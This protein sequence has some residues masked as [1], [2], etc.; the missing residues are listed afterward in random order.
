MADAAR[1][2]QFDITVVDR[3]TRDVQKI[4][5]DATRQAEKATAKIPIIAEDKATAEIRRVQAQTE[6]LF[7]VASRP[8]S[9]TIRDLAT[10]G[11]MKIDAAITA[12]RAKAIIPVSLGTGAAV[13]GL[14]V[15]VLGAVG[16]GAGIAASVPAAADL[17]AALVRITKLTGLEGDAARGLQTDL[18]KMMIQTGLSLDQLSGAY[19]LAGSAGIGS[20]LMKAGDFEGARKEINDFVTVT[21]QASSAFGM[22]AEAT[23]SAL[24]GISNVFKPAEKSV[25]QF[26]NQ[27][28]SGIDA[29]ADS[30]VASEEKILTA[31]SHA[32]AAMAMFKT[33]DKMVKDTIALSAALISTNKSGDQ[34]GEII[35]D[36]YTYAK[37]DAEGKI[38]K[39]LGMSQKDYQA[40][41]TTD[42]QAV[43]DLVA[44][45]Y[46]KM[47]A[48]KQGT[49]AMYFGATGGQALQLSGSENFQKGYAKAQAVVND[50]Y[51]RGAKMA[52]SYEKSL[53]TFWAQLDRLKRT[54]TVLAQVVGGI[55]LPGLNLALRAINAVTGPVVLLV[56]KLTELG[57]KIPGAKFIA[58]ALSLA[59][60][61][62]AVGAVVS[63]VGPLVAGLGLASVAAGVL[64]MWVNLLGLSVGAVVGILASPIVLILGLAA[65]VGY[66]LYKTGY[67]QKAWDKFK[68]SQLGEDF[69]AL[70][71]FLKGGAGSLGGAISAKLEILSPKAIKILT[72]IADVLGGALLWYVDFQIACLEV[73]IAIL[74]K[75]WHV[76]EWLFAGI[77]KIVD[78]VR[79]LPEGIKTALQEAA[80]SIFG[81]APKEGAALDKAFADWAGG[82][83]IAKARPEA[84][85]KFL[86]YMAMPKTDDTLE[87]RKAAVDELSTLIG[88]VSLED[89]RN[90]YNEL[91][92]GAPSAPDRISQKA[93]EAAEVFDYNTNPKNLNKPI[94]HLDV[95]DT[96][97]AEQVDANSAGVR[98]K[99]ADFFGV[100]KY[101]T[102]TNYVPETGLAFLHRGEAVIPAGKNQSGNISM[103]ITFNNVTVSSEADKRW[104][105]SMVRRVATDTIKTAVAQRRT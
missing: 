68:G 105:E 89:W 34:A 93:T 29:V 30:T 61:A 101:A 20:D 62:A 54:F 60:V 78:F 55:F 79:E 27:V 48:S 57:S 15:G 22:T 21:L 42:P 9:I 4:V 41:L 69:K 56:G 73:I 52:E 98:E 18:Q 59:A 85:Q 49:Y 53:K 12:L 74:R 35:K 83:S 99:I 80:P 66:L 84:I 37:R 100:R 71:E 94:Q 43:F 50:E 16:I 87:A 6:K 8:L 70:M 75:V 1:S 38:S 90:K 19:E 7:A 65:A 47:D 2:L 63:V 51:E 44:E 26:L 33:S 45:A 103:P 5:R 88:G 58:A 31:M 23:S 13:A 17:E 40:L 72:S 104:L 36:F 91:N 28:G 39:S 32:S 11:L 81:S 24:S 102:G 10:A 96:G 95:W 97:Y 67:L 92:Q 3:A 46:N 86:D 64:A 25:T 76:A 14:G 77:L 82:Q